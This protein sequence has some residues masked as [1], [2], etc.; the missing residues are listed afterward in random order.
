M[1]LMGKVQN[2]STKGDPILMAL[3][4]ACSDEDAA[5]AFIE[6]QRWGGKAACVL[7]GD[8]DV[9][10]MMNKDGK[11][12]QENYR[13]RCRGCKAQFTVR[14]GT[15]FE[16]SAIPLK[17]WCFAF[18]RAATRKKGVSA[19]EI[20]RQTGI[21]YK[22]SLF[23]LHRIRFAMADSA[24]GLLGPGG[25]D[26]EVDETYI[27]GKMRY[28]G[29]YPP[30]RP[31]PKSNKPCVVALVERGGSAKAMLAGSVTGKTFKQVVLENV[32]PSARIL[33]DEA[34]H[35]HGLNKSFARGHKSV[36]HWRREY[37][38]PG[39]DIHS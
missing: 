5:V 15:V 13:W 23:M 22:S 34:P 33:T 20:H 27:G 32:D 25:G 1:F 31:G 7:C 14:K 10:K 38:R 36:K 29:Q 11:T 30:G 24:P 21:S 39:T 3:P 18:G 37:V 8:I 28:P 12:R 19:L 2:Q 35:Y 9:Y 26:V 6:K 16:D 4:K 17:H